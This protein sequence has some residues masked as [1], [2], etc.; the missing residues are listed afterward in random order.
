MLNK[1]IP[2][3]LIVNSLKICSTD[4]SFRKSN[5]RNT[6][7]ITNRYLPIFNLFS[8]TGLII[9]KTSAQ[10]AAVIAKNI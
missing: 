3:K 9:I 2:D 7:Y 10:L 4:H 6:F 8:S 5:T 1:V